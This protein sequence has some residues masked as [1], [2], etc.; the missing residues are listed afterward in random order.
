MAMMFEKRLL[1]KNAGLRSCASCSCLQP[2]SK[3]Q[4][5]DDCTR[6]HNGMIDG[7]T[8]I[9]LHYFQPAKHHGQQAIV[10]CRATCMTDTS[11]LSMRHGT[12]DTK[13]LLRRC[14][15]SDVV[16]YLIIMDLQGYCR[17]GDCLN[18]CE[19]HPG[20]TTSGPA[21]MSDL[22]DYI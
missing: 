7:S 13:A 14:R 11:R 8:R 22:N 10:I 18:L 1:R 15:L 3:K 20:I 21:F 17:C 6:S 16:V 12:Y 9:G 4:W 5:E 2:R 19:S